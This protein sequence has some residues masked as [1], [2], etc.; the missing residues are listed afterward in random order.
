MA[1]IESILP[2]L[3]NGKLDPTAGVKLAARMRTQE[4]YFNVLGRFKRRTYIV[5]F[6]LEDGKRIRPNFKDSFQQGIVNH[7]IE[8]SS[9][10]VD[11]DNQ[12]LS[13][14]FAYSRWAKSIKAP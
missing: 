1:I 14:L 5:G 7:V 10:S 12:V 3:P 9:R 13:M 8:R 11:W 2:P 4:D 6:A